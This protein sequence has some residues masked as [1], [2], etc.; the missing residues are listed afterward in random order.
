MSKNG[1]DKA[2]PTSSGKPLNKL[3]VSNAEPSDKHKQIIDE[4]FVNGFNKVKSVLSVS[5]DLTYN[6][7]NSVGTLIFSD[8]NNK[9]YIQDKQNAIKAN[10]NIETSQIV[11]ELLNVAY[12]DATDYLD[13][14]TEELKS[15]PPDV[16][17]SIASIR[18]KRKAYK[19]RDGIEVVEETHEIKL[20]DT[21]K[22]V[23]MLA[24][25]CGL[26]EQDNKQRAATVNL[27]NINTDQLNVLL[28][29]ATKALNKG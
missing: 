27:T 4:Y 24:K 1:K 10:A 22:A 6:G 12:S 9:A 3:I 7:A 19:G 8:A 28:Q 14:T 23:D 16:R 13:L 15:L 2:A 26:Y 11:R 18:T 25:Y 17:R 20:K 21:L 29:V 5:P